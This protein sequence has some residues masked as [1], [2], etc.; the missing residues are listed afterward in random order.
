[1]YLGAISQC[2]QRCKGVLVWAISQSHHQ[3]LLTPALLLSSS[4]CARADYRGHLCRAGLLNPGIN[5]PEID[6]LEK[7]RE[8]VPGK[9][10]FLSFSPDKQSGL[11]CTAPHSYWALGASWPF[12]C[13]LWDAIQ[14]QYQ[15]KRC[16][17]SCLS[18]EEPLLE[19]SFWLQFVNEILFK[20]SA[21]VLKLS[22]LLSYINR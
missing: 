22:D 14:K 15:S 10:F 17:W 21:L 4:R 12:S 9:H 11:S 7:E 13:L 20:W 8:A 1:M 6:Q 5:V 19:A 16:Y 18:S 2:Q 3:L